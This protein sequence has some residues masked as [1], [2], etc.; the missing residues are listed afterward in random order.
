MSA[1]QFGL[2]GASA[3]RGFTERAVAADSGLVLNNELYT[4]PLPVPGALRLLTFFDIGRGYNSHVGSS[5]LA[6][7]MTVSSI[8]VG[9][10]YSV[11]RDFTVRLDVARV[12]AS[13]NSASES[14]GDL[15]A[16]VNVILGF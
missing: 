2:V 8:G 9:A 16:H 14:R 1:E 7:S 4:P 10:R 12:G 5:T 13:G 15:Y 11:G 3:V 6:A